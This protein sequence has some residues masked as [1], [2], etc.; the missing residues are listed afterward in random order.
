MIVRVYGLG[1]VAMEQLLSPLVPESSCDLLHLINPAGVRN[2]TTA[3]RCCAAVSHHNGNKC[4]HPPARGRPER[5][6]RCSSGQRQNQ[7]HP[8]TA[9]PPGGSGPGAA[10]DGTFGRLKGPASPGVT[11]KANRQLTLECHQALKQS[12]AHAIT[13][14]SFKAVPT[15]GSP[16]GKREGEGIRKQILKI[17]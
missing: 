12:S 1:L 9:V 16:D 2:A 6:W 8:A 5:H 10:S 4:I 14:K 15:A 17:Y 11:Q 7:L 13:P 3:C